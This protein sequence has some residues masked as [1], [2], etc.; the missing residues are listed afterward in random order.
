MLGT[1]VY[2]DAGAFTGRDIL[3]VIDA[4]RPDVGIVTIAPE[5]PGGMDLV[6]RLVAAGHLVSIGHTGATFEQANEAIDA[7]GF[8]R[9]FRKDRSLRAGTVIAANS[10]GPNFV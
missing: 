3:D 10:L 7:G 5:M 2:G 1:R 4:H 6:R 9:G 8:T